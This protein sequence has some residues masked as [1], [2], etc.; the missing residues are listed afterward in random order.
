MLRSANRSRRRALG[1][2]YVAR[3][4]ERRAPARG[5]DTLTAS[6]RRRPGSMPRQSQCCPI[7]PRRRGE[8]GPFASV[9]RLVLT[10]AGAS[11]GA[12]AIEKLLALG[13]LGTGDEFIRLV[14]NGDRAGAADDCR[15]P[16]LLVEPGL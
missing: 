5:A 13:K 15:Y 6:S 8:P 7:G 11:P 14:R 12:E 4:A 3:R 10:A 2:G 1:R 9:A 16:G